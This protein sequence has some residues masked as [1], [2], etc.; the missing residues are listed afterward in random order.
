MSSFTVDMENPLKLEGDFEVAVKEI[1]LCPISN[2]KTMLKDSIILPNGKKFIFKTIKEF[3]DRLLDYAWNKDIYQKSYFAKYLDPNIQFSSEI[4]D[5]Y[6]SED[7]LQVQPRV[8]FVID[9]KIDM[10][11]LFLPEELL[12]ME[13]PLHHLKEMRT[14]ID[15]MDF[16]FRLPVYEGEPP[17]LRTI[18]NYMIRRILY[19]LRMAETNSEYHIGFTSAVQH[20]ASFDEMEKVL[21]KHRK[22]INLIVQRFIQRFV[23]AVQDRLQKDKIGNQQL[24]DSVFVYS[25]LIQPTYISGLKTRLL[26]VL[27]HSGKFLEP[28]HVSY[29]NPLFFSVDKKILNSISFSLRDDQGEEIAFLPSTRSTHITLAFR[30]VKSK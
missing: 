2:P 3:V 28:V 7:K 12:Q 18:F 5:T 4:L 21:T 6:F 15:S 24:A 29:D 19:M 23:A 25:D 27:F 1:F 13:T 11:K 26:H 20:Y 14:P 22:Q 9:G 10:K 17:A 8:A 30:K 16:N